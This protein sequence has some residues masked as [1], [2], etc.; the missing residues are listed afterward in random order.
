MHSRENEEFK[1]R[2]RKRLRDDVAISDDGMEYP[3]GRDPIS[4]FMTLLNLRL[5][6]SEPRLRRVPL[7][8]GVGCPYPTALK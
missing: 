8:G 5:A 4:I 2:Q 1:L 6:F 7:H 3:R